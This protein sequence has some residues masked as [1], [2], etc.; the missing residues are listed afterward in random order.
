VL[1]LNSHIRDA[2]VAVDEITL[3]LHTE[4]LKLMGTP[5][6]QLGWLGVCEF[7]ARMVCRLDLPS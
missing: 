5:K 2:E 7:A 6:L 1:I 3:T 4:R